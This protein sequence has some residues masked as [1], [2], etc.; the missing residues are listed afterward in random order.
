M[1]REKWSEVQGRTALQAAELD[2]AEALADRLVSGVGAR[3]QGPTI[4][5]EAAD[6]RRRAFSLFARAY[7][8]ARRAV[9]YLRWD[10]G[11]ADDIAPS[12][13][14]GRGG[15]RRRSRHCRG[16]VEHECT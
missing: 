4:V 11:D 14:A 10:Q 13:Y 3:E 5:L 7:D 15:S 2:A 6:R 1:M 12:L 16:G 8:Q 9:I